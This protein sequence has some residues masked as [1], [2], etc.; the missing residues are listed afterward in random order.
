MENQTYV[1]KSSKIEEVLRSKQLFY[2]GSKVSTS[3]YFLDSEAK[4][5]LLLQVR[6]LPNG[7]EDAKVTYYEVH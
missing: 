6:R 5:S 2:L 7:Y 3:R 4:N 1:K